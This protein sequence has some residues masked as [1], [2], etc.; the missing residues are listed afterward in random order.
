VSQPLVAAALIYEKI[1]CVQ[2]TE[3]CLDLIPGLD[4]VW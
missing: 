3:D 4:V 2:K 1:S